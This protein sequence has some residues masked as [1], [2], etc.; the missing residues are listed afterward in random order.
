MGCT[1]SIKA[2][3][4]WPQPPPQEGAT[5]KIETTY[6]VVGGDGGFL[7]PSTDIKYDNDQLELT[8]WY[9]E[10]FS[11]RLQP[12]Q[13]LLAE[14]GVTKVKMQ[15]AAFGEKLTDKADFLVGD[16]H[17]SHAYPCLGINT[18]GGMKMFSQT[19]SILQYLGAKFGFDGTTPEERCGI[20]QI[21]LNA[22]DIWVECYLAKV[23]NQGAG[24]TTDGTG[25]TWFENRVPTW[26]QTLGI[27]LGKE[28]Y[29]GGNMCS[30]ADFAMLNVYEALVFMYGEEKAELLFKD[31][32]KDWVAR[33]KSRPAMKKFFASAIPLGYE[34]MKH[35]Y[36]PDLQE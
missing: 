7:Q 22:A 17:K 9:Y 30:Y 10:G 11:G 16:R 12:I 36:K 8:L 35:D 19:T 18:G 28:D 21:A 14:A 2:P 29:F 20:N 24:A 15:Y 32:L 34:Q 27:N 26:S 25:E 4:Q 5:V 6:K 3:E 23:G 31:N 13:M 1:I 33:M